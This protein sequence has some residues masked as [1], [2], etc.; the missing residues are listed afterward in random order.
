MADLRLRTTI[1]KLRHCWCIGRGHCQSIPERYL[2]KFMF[3]VNL[4]YKV[5]LY[6][7]PLESNGISS[8]CNVKNPFRKTAQTEAQKRRVQGNNKN[9]LGLNYHVLNFRADLYK[10]SHSEPFW[11]Y[12]N[13][14]N[15]IFRFKCASIQE[16]GNNIVL[17]L[18]LLTYFAGASQGKVLPDKSAPWQCFAQHLTSPVTK[19][20]HRHCFMASKSVAYTFLSK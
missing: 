1:E 13:P 7:Q 17:S 14:N 2:L 8:R 20:W 16:D 12:G 15:I 10:T 11:K 18:R 5:N 3:C 19:V 4:T 9:H 6:F